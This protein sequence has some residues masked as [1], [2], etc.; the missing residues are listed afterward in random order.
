MLYNIQRLY[1]LY[2]LYTL[3]GRRD[4]ECRLY[5]LYSTVYSSY[6]ATFYTANYTANDHDDHG[7][8][9]LWDCVFHVLSLWS[10]LTGQGPGF[11]RPQCPIERVGQL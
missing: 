11:E 10:G 4:N 5:S 1:T 3:Q 8:G 2:P 6:T 7:H 9:D